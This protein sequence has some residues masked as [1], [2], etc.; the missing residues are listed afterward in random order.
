MTHITETR[1]IGNH[2]EMGVSSPEQSPPTVSEILRFGRRRRI[3]RREKDA[4]QSTWDSEGGA[5][6]EGE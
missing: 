2:A 5:I 4:A 6:G 1:V 3:R